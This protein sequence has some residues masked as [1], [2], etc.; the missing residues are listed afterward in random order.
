MPALAVSKMHGTLN[1]FIVVDLRSQPSPGDVFA[2]ARK[3]CDRRG[4]IGAD[5]VLLIEPAAEA[6]VRMRVINAD[7]SEAEMCGNGIRC[8]TRFLYE[9]GEGT[10]FRIQTLAGEI[11]SG[12]VGTDPFL[13]RVDVG[14]PHIGARVADFPDGV[15][16]SV[17]NPHV[18]VFAG[19]DD[20]DLLGAAR[21]L[22]AM[23]V[24]VAQVAG[25]ALRVRHFERGAGFTQACGTGTV[26][27]AAIAIDAGLVR[28][29]LEARV[30]GGTL[31]V[32]WDGKGRAYL[33]GPAE[34]V[35]DAAI[36]P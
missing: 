15:L 30:P 11:V 18:V 9:K 34:R 20:Y 21:A 24:H 7:G 25:A 5:G 35:F 29:P 10:H 22:P 4:G 16:V 1:D 14:V 26:A 36:D 33:T 23:N 6:A 3:W 32:E 2:F 27:A 12:V 13:A 28:S 31:T 8:V 19:V 17:G